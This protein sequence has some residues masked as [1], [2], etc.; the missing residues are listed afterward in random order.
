MRATIL[1]SLVTLTATTSLHAAV[2]TVRN[3]PAQVAVA[4]TSPAA[5]AR[6]RANGPAGL[7]TLWSRYSAE[8]E[9]HRANPLAVDAQWPSIERAL[10][11]VAGQ[12]DAWSARL[13]WYTDL[14]A[15]KAAA[16]AQNKPILSLRLLGKLTDEY[17]CA[18]SRFFRTALYAN[19]GIAKT[20]RENFI[21]HWQSERPVPVMT[22]DLGDGRVVKRTLTGNSAH[23]ML[24][25][26]GRPLDVLPGLYGPGAFARWLA[27]GQKLVEV[28]NTEPREKRDAFLKTYHRERITALA[29]SY[30][31]TGLR[32][33]P[34][35]RLRL[36]NSLLETPLPKMQGAA[37]AAPVQRLTMS[38]ALVELPL[39]NVSALY[40]TTPL[41]PENDAAMWQVMARRAAADSQLDAN[42]LSLM[43]T[44]TA[45]PVTIPTAAPVPARG[46]VREARELQP[47]IM[48][49]D[50]NL[51]LADFLAPA[52]NVTVKDTDIVSGFQEALALDSVRNEYRMHAP[53]H[54]WFAKGEAPAE[55]EALNA[56]V[57]S[58]VFQTP[59]T[60]PWLGLAPTGLYAALPGDGLVTN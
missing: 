2:P 56:R 28:W 7:E 8:I 16:K 38:K 43:R 39:L 42:S 26:N 53:I 45:Q 51:D 30:E 41:R 31:G 12:R 20:L 36:A 4:D 6:L 24:D 5:L 47:I 1:I 3:I 17:S 14:A 25:A 35:A 33:S 9:A 54:A 34:A 18:N 49:S 29:N 11:V 57:Y 15:A 55:L 58:D 46:A 59:R 52:R 50:A 10:D 23:Y 44:K 60:D 13:F 27:G 21:L 32:T 48:G 37:P 19:E 22:I 40:N